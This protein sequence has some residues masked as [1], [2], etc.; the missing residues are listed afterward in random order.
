MVEEAGE[1][2]LFAERAAGIDIG[3][4]G[5]EAAVRVPGPG[6]RRMQEVRSWGAT[7]RELE[8]LA[9]WL[10]EHGVTR[11]GMEST[12]DYWKPVFFTLER[13]GLECWLYNSRQV[14][15]LPGRPK[16]DKADAVWLARITERGLVRSSFVPPQE[17]RV[18]RAH[19]RYRRRLVQAR[20]AQ[21][22]RTEKL[23]EEGHLKLSG[24]I[25]GVSGRAMLDALAAGE[26]VSEKRCGGVI[27]QR[28]CPR[29]RG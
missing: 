3:K 9:D 23:L 22:N 6:G 20:A 12:S 25:S 8:A 27:G 26:G 13:R 2:P 4:A 21:M 15:A 28:Q 17:I 5:L 19:T 14:K 16:T 29:S 11:V 24:V 7:R 10:E 1:E 18:L